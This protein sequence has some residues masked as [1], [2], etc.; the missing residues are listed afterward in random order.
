MDCTDERYD[1]DEDE[2]VGKRTTGFFASRSF[3]KSC[4]NDTGD[5]KVPA[6]VFRGKAGNSTKGRSGLTST[7]AA[8]AAL[9]YVGSE[10]TV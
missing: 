9:E 8:A 4:A 10:D 5:D 3:D 2:D 7:A 1:D 6:V